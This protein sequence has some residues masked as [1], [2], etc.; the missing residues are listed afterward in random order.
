LPVLSESLIDL[1]Y[2][3]R[4]PVAA[5]LAGPDHLVL[6]DLP[7]MERKDPRQT[8]SCSC[9]YCLSSP[10]AAVPVNHF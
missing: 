2:R 9:S 5:S 7:G 8:N 3:K 4:R 1:K 6:H 10:L